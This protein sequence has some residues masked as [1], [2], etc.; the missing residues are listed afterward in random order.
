MVTSDLRPGD[1]A[2]EVSITHVQVERSYRC[3]GPVYGLLFGDS[4]STGRVAMIRLVTRLAPQD[5]LEVGVGTGL[6][7]AQYSATARISGVDVSRNMLVRTQRRVRP[8]DAGRIELRVMSAEMVD[9]ATASLDC[10]TL[11]YA[12]SVTPRPYRLAAKLRCVYWRGGQIEIV[13]HLSGQRRLRSVD[14]LLH[15]LA[16]MLGLRAEFSL[17]HHT[18]SQPWQGLSVESVNLQSL[19]YLIHARNV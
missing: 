12:L 13:D 18:L 16:A 4:L 19:S 7:R 17:E 14:V 11:P 1:A 3:N 15:P 10:V 8:Q 9:F 5:D 6:T 2:A